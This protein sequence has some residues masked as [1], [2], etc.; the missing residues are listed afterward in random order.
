MAVTVHPSIGASDGLHDR[1]VVYD[2]STQLSV[3]VTYN[4]SPATIS[5]TTVRIAQGGTVV[6]LTPSVSGGV[7]SY[8][9]TPSNLAAIGCS[10]VD[11]T[12]QVTVE[13]TVSGYP[14][15]VR[16]FERIYVTPA[17]PMCPVSHSDIIATYAE[18]GDTDNMPDGATTWDTQIQLSWRA[19]WNTVNRQQVGQ[20]VHRIVHQQALFELVRHR[21]LGDIAQYLVATRAATSTIRGGSDSYWSGIMRFH[22]ESEV[23]EWAQVKAAFRD[24]SVS[25]TGDEIR[26]TTRTVKASH[27]FAGRTVPAATGYL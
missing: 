20:Q 6:S 21:A 26:T 18:L 2:S 13:T 17:L 1:C 24:G 10:S 27:S 9:V 15:V 8:T 5:D 16:W 22:R 3:S 19:I 25:T 23:A 7:I 4:G 11:T 14:N 12:F